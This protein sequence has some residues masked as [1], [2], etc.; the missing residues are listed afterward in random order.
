M[1]LD[2]L[3]PLLRNYVSQTQAATAATSAFGAEMNRIG[4]IG[5]LEEY[6][7]SNFESLEKTVKVFD[8]E[9]KA[10]EEH[11][12]AIA[13]LNKARNGNES[14]AA[15][16]RLLVKEQ[17]QA[18]NQALDAISDAKDDIED[19]KRAIKFKRE[20]EIPAAIRNAE[21]EA[22]EKILAAKNDLIA[23]ND[24]LKAKENDLVVAKNNVT[25]A[26]DKVRQAIDGVSNAKAA[27]TNA[28]EE[29][30]KSEVN[31]ANAIRDVGLEQREA[32]KVG[33]GRISA[34]WAMDEALNNVKKAEFNVVKVTDELGK[35]QAEAASFGLKLAEAQ[36]KIVEASIA[37]EAAQVSERKGL[38]DIA[39]ANL[40]YRDSVVNVTDANLNVR[41]AESKILDV[42]REGLRQ[43]QDLKDKTFEVTVAQKEYSKV[44]A[45]TASNS[46][47]AVDAIREL[48]DAELNVKSTVLDLADAR[49]K[50]NKAQ[51]ALQSG[52]EG[53]TRDE[54]VRDVER[55]KLD[56][57]RVRNS[58]AD[59]R[60]AASRKRED[61]GLLS[62]DGAAARAAALRKVAAAQKGVDEQREK[63]VGVSLNVADAEL[64]VLKAKNDVEKAQL[65]SKKAL[66]D[67]VD[68][69]VKQKGLVAAIA[70][71][72]L[73]QS[74]AQSGLNDVMVDQKSAVMAVLEAMF[75]LDQANRG[76]VTASNEVTKAT[77]GISSAQ[78]DY[79]KALVAVEG[80]VQAV[81]N[82]EG[83]LVQKR[84]SVLEA[85][86]AIRN[87][88]AALAQAR[89]DESQSLVKVG[90][91]E[92]AIG[93]ARTAVEEA[94]KK[95]AT[96]EA[97]RTEKLALLSKQN[98]DLL[99]MERDLTTAKRDLGRMQDDYNLL[100]DQ[101]AVARI[102]ERE[103]LDALADKAKAVADTQKTE[104]A[105]VREANI[106]R[107]KLKLDAGEITEE[108]YYVKVA[109]EF[110]KYADFLKKEYPVVGDA[111]KKAFEASFNSQGLFDAWQK[112]KA[113]AEA[114]GLTL[115]IKTVFVNSDGNLVFGANAAAGTYTGGG[116]PNNVPAFRFGGAVGAGVT[117]RFNEV[118]EE[119][120]WSAA[121][122]QISRLRGGSQVGT[123][124]QA[125]FVIPADITRQLSS[126]N[127]GST[128]V[129]NSV[130]NYEIISNTRDP[131]NSGRQFMEYTRRSRLRGGL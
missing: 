105:A 114:K 62:V 103:D 41:K 68:V 126:V 128:H 26:A 106:A 64:T 11:N 76:V 6:A 102:K 65:G 22:A 120:F 32:D 66:L 51:L 112:A 58:V 1:K 75:S 88:E 86:Q 24:E 40:S 31:L 96:A 52:V 57:A 49:D 15:K 108:Q 92:S 20:V 73:G 127:S 83:E 56:L 50:L 125:G 10:K 99:K 119:S 93:R 74:K 42:R 107:F 53:K 129:D 91:V 2:Q 95:I 89:F 5:K 45:E 90:E 115:E 67:I 7:K 17:A 54:L 14:D 23:R 70:A 85:N 94:T 87:E 77:W 80:K 117:A 25:V 44:V 27:L 59:A 81:K 82:A 46:R 3:P 8:N 121:T 60:V 123:F 104:Y 111:A 34:L 122:G 28:N 47:K 9:K 43:V 63:S 21:V 69:N 98:D 16:A 37:V 101:Q 18:R 109:G 131:D 84:Q 72:L 79:E 13:A 113:D 61:I 130:H 19:R 110:G 48:R 97:D 29:V 55:A 12:K 124:N 38:L 36:H 4:G 35:K 33:N 71:A 116:K 78:L 100:L 39:S 30:R 118:G